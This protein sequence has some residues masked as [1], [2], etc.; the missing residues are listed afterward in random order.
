MNI[1][2]HPKHFD[3]VIF[4]L[5][6]VITKTAKVHAAAWKGMFDEY[7]QK[8]SQLGLVD[9]REFSYD[10]DYL[11][12]VDGKPRYEG[13]QSFLESREI[14]LP[15]GNVDD[16][17][18]QET[19][20]GL[21]NRKNTKFLEVL[22]TDGIEVYT[23]TV[24]LIKNLQAHNIRIGVAS[25]SKNCQHVLKVTG[26]E[27]YFE[28]RVDGVVSHELGLKGKPEPDI[29]LR[30]AQ[31]LNM[32]PQR[33]VVIEDAVS[34]VAAG[35]KGGFA[36]VIGV[37]RESNEKDLKDNGAHVV[38]NGFKEVTTETIDQWLS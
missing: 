17:D 31:N 37:A 21:G 2:K 32:T 12:Y 14:S 20:C 5:D 24:D 4:D 26:L 27:K 22:N 18:D 10:K 8:R 7:L 28:T 1:E 29:F 23:S 11:T 6:G 3:C 35:F 34:G 38:V 30:A 13:V 25:S 36:L 15:F 9:F 33:S 19:I 16:E